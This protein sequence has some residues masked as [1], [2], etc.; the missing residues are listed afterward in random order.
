MIAT[1]ECLKCNTEF[2][3]KKPYGE[4]FPEKI[5]CPQSGCKGHAKRSFSKSLKHFEVAE[6]KTGNAKTGYTNT[7]GGYTP[8]PSTPLKGRGMSIFNNNGTVG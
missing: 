5:K 2:E 6:G 8:A 1:Y 3:Y 7:I 4:E